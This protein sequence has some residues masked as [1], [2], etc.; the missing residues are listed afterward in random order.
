MSGLDDVTSDCDQVMI[1]ILEELAATKE[2][3]DAMKEK[4]LPRNSCTT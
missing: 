4:D 2:E 3:K 1:A